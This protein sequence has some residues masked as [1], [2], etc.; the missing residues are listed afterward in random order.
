MDD[1]SKQEWRSVLVVMH[2][3]DLAER[4][5]VRVDVDHPAEDY[6]LEAAAGGIASILGGNRTLETELVPV[7]VLKSLALG[8]HAEIRVQMP[9]GDAQRN[10]GVELLF[11]RALGHGVHGADEL[12]AIGS[13]LVKQGSR[14]RRIERE[15]FKEA[16][17]VI[18]EVI[19]GLREIREK[20]S[21]TFVQRHVVVLV[22]FQAGTEL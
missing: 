18:R 2:G 15:S 7:R 9:H 16:V 14:A 1:A 22:F 19:F 4:V 8:R 11:G 3:E 5:F 6:G 17:H 10:A 21:V 12:V 20:D 13:F